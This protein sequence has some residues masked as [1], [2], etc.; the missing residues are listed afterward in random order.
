[1]D[2]EVASEMLCNP[3]SEQQANRNW[4]TFG[5][6]RKIEARFHAATLVHDTDAPEPPLRT[7]LKNAKKY[8]HGCRAH[9]GKI[10]P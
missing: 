4:F 5:G 8:P 6:C 2:N 1:M 9:E 10:L 7:P 3:Y